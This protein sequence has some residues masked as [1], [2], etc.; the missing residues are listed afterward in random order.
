MRFAYSWLLDC[1]DT[2]C[3][4]QVLVD[5]LS[6]IGVEAALVGGGVKQGSFVVAKVLEVLAHPDAHKLKVCKV[7]DGVEVLQIVCGA[8]NVRGG[9]ITVLARVGAY[10]QES[11]ITISKAVIR[12]LKAVVCFALWK[13]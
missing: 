9:M 2:E 4:A 3:S 8:S 5:K 7:Y 6:S 13:S 10:I 1:L 12:G 11:G